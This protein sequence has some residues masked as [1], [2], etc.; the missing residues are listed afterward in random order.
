MKKIF[1]ILLLAMAT[2]S[3]SAQGLL[4]ALKK[5]ASGAASNAVTN[6]TGSSTLGNIVANLLGTA[7]VTENSIKGTWSYSTPAVVFESSNVLA[8]MGGTAASTKIETSLQTQLKKI[9]FTEGKIQLTFADDNKGTITVA[10]KSIPFTYSLEGSDLTVTL[11]STMFNKLSKSFTMNAKITG[12]ELQIAMKADKLANFIT[13]MLTKVG[14]A[15]N[16]SA[17]STVTS[18]VN[19]IDGMYLGLKYKKN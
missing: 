14:S 18:L 19:K 2:S 4:D 10:G 7:T 6:A 15:S 3:M 12:D 9:G 16:S 11:G 17:L 13:S 8:N 1:C 5:A